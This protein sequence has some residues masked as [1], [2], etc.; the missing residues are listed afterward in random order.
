LNKILILCFVFS[1]LNLKSQIN[2]DSLVNAIK[3]SSEFSIKDTVHYTFGDFTKFENNTKTKRFDICLDSAGT[4]CENLKVSLIRYEYD[5]IGRKTLT[6]GYNIQGNYNLWDFPP[7]EIISYSN[8]SIITDTYAH[9]VKLRKRTIEKL[10][11][12]GRL[13]TEKH[14]NH[15]LAFTRGTAIT[16]DSTNYKIISSNINATNELINDE[17]GVATIEIY[18]NNFSD[19]HITKQ[20]FYDKDAK[21]VNG[22]HLSQSTYMSNLSESV[23]KPFAYFV[24][25]RDETSSETSTKYYNASHQLVGQSSYGTF[26]IFE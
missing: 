6:T 26:L 25:S 7:I 15:D 5:S 21:L 8:D 23:P 10:D 9:N 22:F 1:A 12:M 18:V 4:L 20:F 14:Y 17:F 2:L 3:T 24:I 11:L 19:N 16:F 13:E